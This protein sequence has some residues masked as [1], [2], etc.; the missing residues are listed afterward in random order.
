MDS[1]I[2]VDAGHEVYHGSP[3]VTLA[4][5]HTHTHDKHLCM[6]AL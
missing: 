1:A 6:A 5:L 3:L 2:S 4:I